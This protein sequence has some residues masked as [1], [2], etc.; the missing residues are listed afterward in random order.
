MWTEEN[1]ELL[2]KLYPYET[3]DNL[4]KSF[5]WCNWESLKKYANKNG[6]K[7]DKTLFLITRKGTLEPLLYEEMSSYYWIGF[8]AADG[9]FYDNK[10]H[11]SIVCSKKDKEHLLKLSKLLETSLHKTKEERP[12]DIKYKKYSQKGKYGYRIS[13]KHKVPF[14]KIM[15]KFDFHF[16]KT[17]NPPDFNKYL[18]FTN[19]QL[20]SILIG[21]IDGDGNISKWQNITIVCHKSWGKFYIDLLDRLS[22]QYRKTMTKNGYFSVRLKKDVYLKLKKVAISLNLPL[23]ERKWFKV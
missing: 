7:R 19:D 8:I 20:F 3:K 17:Y 1:T 12:S 22:I 18:N 13:L 23:M 21:L 15:E 9:C 4:L 6:V 2:K 5:D 10:Y 16:K 11:F 14:L